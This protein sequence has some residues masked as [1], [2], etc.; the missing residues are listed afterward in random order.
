MTEIGQTQSLSA[1]LPGQVVLWGERRVKQGVQGGVVEVVAW[2][3]EGKS[4]TRFTRF[5]PVYSLLCLEALAS[6]G[7]ELCLSGVLD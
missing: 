1:R 4:V 2:G 6:L 3:G 7:T 5:F